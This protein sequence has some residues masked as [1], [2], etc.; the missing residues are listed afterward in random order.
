MTDAVLRRNSDE[1]RAP[2]LINGRSYRFPARPV[3]VIC[4][5]G[6]DPEYIDAAMKAGVAP[7]LTRM[8]GEGF[9]AVALA[10][11]PTFTNP[12]NVAIACGAPPAVTGVAGNYYLDRATGKEVMVLDGH[13]MLVDT[14]F[15]HFAAAGT[16]V[17]VV[18]A[19]D[20][21]LRA[22]ARNMDGIALSAESPEGAVA[23][24]GDRAPAAATD[25]YSEALSIYVLDAGIRLLE[26]GRGRILYLSLSDYVQHKHPPEAPEALAFM[27][28]VDER[29]GRLVALGATVCIVADHGMTD[30]SAADGS[31][32]ITYVQDELEARFGAG[33]VRVICPITDPFVRHHASLG[34][35]VR[36]YIKDASLSPGEVQAALREN[37]D[38]ALALLADE[39]CARF[40]MP[41]AGE[42]DVVVVAAP[43]VALGATREEH[44]LTA[45]A[46][47]RLRSHGGLAEQDVPFILSHPL[48][49]E[50][51]DRARA[52]LRNYDIFDFAINGVT[53]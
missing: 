44:D 53:R 33:S 52:G 20:K 13:Q 50:Y 31:P 40:E 27:Q 8:I 14:I 41:I 23:V 2:L 38:I 22:L 15:A 25:K 34:G 28:A 37:R 26:A 32:R 29:L 43:G 19:K 16:D 11:M 30:M 49:A 12:N 18:T 6:C 10:A 5:D 1:E 36:V 24:L 46:G 9:S 7:N 21:L 51:A 42:G 39:A 48:T 47:Q 3:V 35:F 17:A 4:F 45:L